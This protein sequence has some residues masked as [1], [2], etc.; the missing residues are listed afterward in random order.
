MNLGY[1]K[2]SDKKILT[3]SDT[4]YQSSYPLINETG[5]DYKDFN[6]FSS[7]WDYNFYQIYNDKSISVSV[8]PFQEAKETKTFFGSKL[9][10]TPSILSIETFDYSENKDTSKDFWYEVKNNLV[11]IHLY[12]TNMISKLLKTDN[13]RNKIKNSITK[14]RN[15]SLFTEEFFEEYIQQ[16]LVKIYKISSV[17]LFSRGDRITQDLFLNTTPQTRESLLFVEENGIVLDKTLEDILIRKDISNLS[18][19]QLSLS[20]TFD[21]I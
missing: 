2:V 1:H 19:A 3:L 10:S 17:K 13:L 14:L 20:I 4:V 7:T 12:P 11:E 15:D 21:K 16:N 6:I 9:I 8:N 5:L 18:N